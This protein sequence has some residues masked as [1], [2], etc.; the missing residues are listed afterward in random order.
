MR[1]LTFNAKNIHVCVCARARVCVITAKKKEK[2]AVISKRKNMQLV[3]VFTQKSML[4]E[5]GM[6]FRLGLSEEK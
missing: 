1:L 5:R 4:K 6:V 3:L 2:I